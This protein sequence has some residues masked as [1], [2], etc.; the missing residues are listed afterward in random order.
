MQY[1][2]WQ[3][4]S[5]TFEVSQVPMLENKQADALSKLSFMTFDHFSK[6]GPCRNPINPKHR[7]KGSGSTTRRTNKLDDT[8]LRFHTTWSAT[9]RPP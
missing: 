9:G 1:A 4:L 5:K 8:L 7:C 6:K 2:I 3:E